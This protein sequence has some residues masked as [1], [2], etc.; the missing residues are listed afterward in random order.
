MTTRPSFDLY[1]PEEQ[2][3]YWMGPDEGYPASVLRVRL[4][5]HHYAG[6]GIKVTD[7]EVGF[8]VMVGPKWHRTHTERISHQ[9]R[10]EAVEKR[11]H[12]LWQFLWGLMRVAIIEVTAD[13]ENWTEAKRADFFSKNDKGEEWLV[14]VPKR[15]EDVP[16][17]WKSVRVKT[18]G[19]REGY[20]LLP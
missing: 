15:K 10:M 20:N 1:E 6:D 11:S 18:L 7:S 12:E 5:V 17:V 16:G 14:P 8:E 2:T 9:G 4:Y 19:L 3:H 13:G